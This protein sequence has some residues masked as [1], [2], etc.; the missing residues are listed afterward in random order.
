[1][2]HTVTEAAKSHD[3]PSASWRT[4]KTSDK[5]QYEAK[6]LTAR[7]ADGITLSLRPKGD[8]VGREGGVLLV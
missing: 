2:V 7:G 5:I 8:G 6:G 3:M 1:M 4:R